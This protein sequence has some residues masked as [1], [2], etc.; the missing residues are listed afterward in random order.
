MIQTTRLTL[1][2]ENAGRDAGPILPHPGV[3]AHLVSQVPTVLQ[4]PQGSRSTY[5][6]THAD[7]VA[8]RHKE[9]GTHDLLDTLAEIQALE[10][11]LLVADAP[12]PARLIRAA[13]QALL[14]EELARRLAGGGSAP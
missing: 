2:V 14:A 7:L 10:H 3:I 4:L 5:T 9:D 1:I 8:L 6:L 12:G 11:G 13:G